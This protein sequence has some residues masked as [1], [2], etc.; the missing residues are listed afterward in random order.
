MEQQSNKQKFWQVC[1]FYGNLALLTAGIIAP[2][3]SSDVKT[4]LISSAVMNLF[5][6][7]RAHGG[8]GDIGGNKNADQTTQKTTP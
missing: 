5:M 2:H 7:I 3:L 1:T 8:F 4:T 6:I